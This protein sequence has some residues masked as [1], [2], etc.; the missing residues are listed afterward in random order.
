MAVIGELAINIVANTK[1]F[2]RSIADATKELHVFRRANVA[3]AA[4]VKIGAATLT[5]LTA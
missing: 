4:G 3:M 5:G 2:G 1:K